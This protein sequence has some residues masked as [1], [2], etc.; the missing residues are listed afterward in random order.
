MAEPWETIR[1][2]AVKIAKESLRNLAEG[3]E[4]DEFVKDQA[5]KF[6]KEY[7][8]STTAATEAQ[9]EEAKRNLRHLKAQTKGEALRLRIEAST[10]VKTAVGGIL[11]TVA[12]VLL[13]LVPKLIPAL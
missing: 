6:A 1:D 5:T 13:D 4:I 8:I 11:E 7:W 9:K 2:E 12:G 10:E 3:A